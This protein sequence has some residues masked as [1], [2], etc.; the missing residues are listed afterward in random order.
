VALARRARPSPRGNPEHAPQ[1]AG[2]LLELVVVGREALLDVGRAL[3]E[4][5][6]HIRVFDGGVLVGQ[7]E[8]LGQHQPQ[9]RHLARVGEVGPA[10]LRGQPAELD[11]HRLV[12]RPVQVL[13]LRHVRSPW[14]LRA[15]VTER[16]MPGAPAARR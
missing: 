7:L 11:A 14:G 15:T 9:R 6:H 2:A 4:Q 8:G 3:P 1:G 13:P 12:D 10:R 16:K 5:R